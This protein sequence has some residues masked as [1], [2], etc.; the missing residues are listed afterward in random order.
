MEI[1]GTG[2]KTLISNGLKI[3]FLIT[4]GLGINLIFSVKA[5]AYF[6]PG[7][8]GLI[9]QGLVAGI[10]AAAITIRLFWDK[11]KNYLRIL[12]K[13]DDEKSDHSNKNP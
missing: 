4:C 10:A 8:G 6:D 2:M 9:L 12:F 13:R 3:I 11:I 5:Y 1:S 7:T